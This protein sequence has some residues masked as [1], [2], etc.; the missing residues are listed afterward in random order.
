MLTAAPNEV[1]IEARKR[2]NAAVH[3]G[4]PLDVGD[5]LGELW[6]LGG[7]VGEREGL[8]AQHEAE[9]PG[10]PHAADRRTVACSARRRRRPTKDVSTSAVA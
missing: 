6:V 2:A 4:G 7:L 5:A 10:A 1:T 8:L 3:L 9:A